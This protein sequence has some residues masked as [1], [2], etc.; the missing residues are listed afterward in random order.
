MPV[1]WRWRDWTHKGA[2]R[3]QAA[4]HA[5]MP[6]APVG[7][8]EPS[9]RT[10]WIRELRDA[11]LL[12]DV[13]ANAACARNGAN[14]QSSAHLTRPQYRRRR[15]A[16]L[17]TVSPNPDVRNGERRVSH[18]YAFGG[19]AR[20]RPP[21]RISY[22]RTKATG[23]HVSSIAALVVGPPTVALYGYRDEGFRRSRRART[24]ESS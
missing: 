11:F 18:V 10:E 6:P 21:M 16:K 19:A 22:E 13:E 9:G 24:I 7:M 12:P 8:H 17:L 2:R 23:F 3:C 4:W 5:R 1:I 20:C 14:G 15:V